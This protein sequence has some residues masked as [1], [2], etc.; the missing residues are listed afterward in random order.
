MAIDPKLREIRFYRCLLGLGMD[1]LMIALSFVAVGL[2]LHPLA[3][4]LGIFVVGTRQQALGIIAHDGVHRLISR[5]RRV[6]DLVAQ[7]FCYWPMGAD[8]RGNRPM[9]LNHHRHLGTSQDPELAYYRSGAPH[10]D[11]PISRG[12]LLWQLTSACFGAN[13]R[14]IF[15]IRQAMPPD[16][17]S[18]KLMPLVVN[19][20]FVGICAA[21]GAWWAAALWYLST[22]TTMVA[23][24][25]FRTWIEHLGSAT[26]HRVH[27]PA[28]LRFWM[29]PHG[30]WM[31]W[32][33]HAH[34]AVPYYNLARVRAQDDSVP[35][36]GFWAWIRQ[37]E[38]SAPA[39][40]GTLP[41]RDAA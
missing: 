22:C 26:T 7:I 14:E 15:R 3:W 30:C 31:H 16:V 4:V 20:A 13:W 32:E 10:W 19:A 38:T 40:S 23:A 21:T 25:T 29:T 9:H 11:A 12:R 18:G 36:V 8:L 1:W 33:H 37:L 5:D 39:P 35:V 27:L 28:W 17:L 6:N 34:P 2:T 41:R 24:W